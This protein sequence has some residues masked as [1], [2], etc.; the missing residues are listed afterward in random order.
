[1]AR[2]DDDDDVEVAIIRGPGAKAFLA[3]LNPPS[4]DDDD[5]EEEEDEKPKKKKADAGG[6]FKYFTR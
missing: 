3:S 1:M 4:D 5:D 6:A 2:S